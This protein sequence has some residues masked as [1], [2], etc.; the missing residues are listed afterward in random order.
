MRHR[1][2]KR[3]SFG[4]RPGPRLALLRNLVSSLVEHERIKTTLPKAKTVR[5]LV[6]KAIT[7]GKGATLTSRRTLLSRYPHQPTVKK[8]V[9]EL[10]PRFKNRPGGYTR[11]MKLGDRAGD[12]AKMAYIEFVDYDPKSPPVKAIEKAANKAKKTKSKKDAA[13]LLKKKLFLQKK[14]VKKHIRQVQAKSRNINRK[15]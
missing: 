13:T 5:R 2:Q 11:I 15:K 1:L 14:K 7:T 12:C 4:L 8:I 3:S 10:A 9:D 6:E